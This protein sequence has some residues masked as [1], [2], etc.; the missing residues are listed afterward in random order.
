MERSAVSSLHSWTFGWETYFFL[1]ILFAVFKKKNPG[2][3]WYQYKDSS[4]GLIRIE[5]TFSRDGVL[6]V[7][8]PNPDKLIH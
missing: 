2:K 5:A 8:I 4:L 6:C 3:I 1:N 7:I